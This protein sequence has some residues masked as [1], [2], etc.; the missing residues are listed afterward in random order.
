MLQP[1][2]WFARCKSAPAVVRRLV[3]AGGTSWNAFDFHSKKRWLV[4]VVR[5]AIAAVHNFN[6]VHG[7]WLHPLDTP[8]AGVRRSNSG[9]FIDHSPV[10]AMIPNVWSGTS[11]VPAEKK[12]RP[13]VM[14]HRFCHPSG[15]DGHLEHRTKAFSKT[16]L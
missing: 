15:R 1:S 16:I 13:A 12:P 11:S 7:V 14:M 10:S 2:V 8:S 3:S 6:R 4:L 9:R 5:S